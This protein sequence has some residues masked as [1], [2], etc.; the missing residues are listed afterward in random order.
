MSIQKNILDQA[1]ALK[2]SV[3][4]ATEKGLMAS[5]K[6]LR[7]I[8]KVIITLDKNDLYTVVFGKASTRGWKIAF[9]YEDIQSSQLA[10]L[11]HKRG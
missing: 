6:G 2:F 5:L 10:W 4:V 1:P 8:N 11:I 3:V 7:N 9:Q